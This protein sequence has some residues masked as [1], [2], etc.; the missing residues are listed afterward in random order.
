[1]EN[2]V[3][4]T[5]GEYLINSDWTIGMTHVIFTGNRKLNRA[6]VTGKIMM[7]ASLQ[8]WNL[9]LIRGSLVEVAKRS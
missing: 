8:R 4:T 2:D 9:R 7:K 5:F 3:I 6:G 1:M